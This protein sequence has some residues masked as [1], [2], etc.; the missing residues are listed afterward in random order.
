MF[1]QRHTRN[2]FQATFT[3]IA[4]IYH[5]TVY[6]L[7]MSERNAVVGLVMV[8]SK[9][10]IM[11]AVFLLIF[12]TLGIRS[13]PIR[14]SFFVYI[15]SGIFM[16]MTH[17]AAL[18]AVLG[19]EGSVSALMK[20]V[21]LNTA[22]TISA[23]ALSVLYQQFLACAVLLLM[24]NTFIEPVEIDR[25]YPCLAMFLMAWFSGCCIGMVFRAVQPWWP[26][27]VLMISQLYTRANMI[28]SG[29]MFVANTMPTMVLNMFDWNPLF[30]II[31]Q[32]RGFAFINYTP[33]NSSV[34]YPIYCSLALAMIGL[35]GEFFTRSRVSLSWGAGR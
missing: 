17:N 27:G 6:K 8:I 33:H 26:K 12:S 22:I 29:K 11:V 4:L 9:A 23:S 14:G 25:I 15:M 19:A 10:M 28:S 35:M 16:F 18:G 2:V 3:T 20:H 7:R 24:T 1:Q 34:T 21:P 32:T 31:D 30:H 13:S 5:M